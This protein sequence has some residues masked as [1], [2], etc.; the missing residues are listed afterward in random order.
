MFDSFWN[1]F[2][3]TWLKKYSPLLWN[4]HG[5]EDIVNRTNNHLE[6]YNRRMN[7]VFPVAHPNI[8]SFVDTIKTEANSYIETY[9]LIK[10]GRLAHPK[11]APVRFATIPSDYEVF[12]CKN[13]VLT[14]DK[15]I[16]KA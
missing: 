10:A 11:H 7:E 8:L 5:N 3:R 6:R 13:P 12:T 14:K 4:V 16:K 1:Y 9:N 15:N 2:Q